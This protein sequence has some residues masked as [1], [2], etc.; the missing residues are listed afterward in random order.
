MDIGVEPDQTHGP[1]RRWALAAP[2]VLALLWVLP[3]LASDRP[4]L[5]RDYLVTGVPA[6][7]PAPVRR[8]DPAVLA[9]LGERVEVPPPPGGW[10]GAPQAVDVFNVFAGEVMV[11]HGEREVCGH[12]H[13]A[14]T[15]DSRFRA[16]VGMVVVPV[17]GDLEPIRVAWATP[18]KSRWIPTVRIGAPSPVQQIDTARL[19]VRTACVAVA[20]VLAFTALMGFLSARDGLF[21]G[22][23]LLCLLAVVWQAIVSGLSG[24]PEPWLPVGG[25]ASRW[26]VALSCMGLSALLYVMWLLVGAAGR[27]RACRQCLLRTVGGCWLLGIVLAAGLPMPALG[28]FAEAVDAIFAAGCVAVF[29]LGLYAAWRRRGD[30]LAGIAAILPFLVMVLLDLADSRLLIEYR[31]EA[32]QL[33]ITW[34]LTVSAYALNLRLGRLRRQRDEMQLLAD[35]DALTGLAN[36]RAGLVRLERHFRSAAVRGGML[37]VAFLDIDLFKRINDV[38]GHHAGD[39][40]LV[41]V[42]QTLAAA[43]RDAADVVRMGGEEFLVMLPGVSGDSAWQ[44]METVRT[45]VARVAAGLGIPGLTVT[46]SIGIASQHPQ[47][48]DASMLLRRADEAMY[49]A[50]R[51]GRNRVVAAETPVAGSGG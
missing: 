29:A 30:A 23:A 40:V 6:L 51:N 35:T 34:F 39:R 43:I 42:A 10:S 32:I 19:L 9:G 17:A 26:L 1:W 41:A 8:C 45:Q 48:H 50:K 5:G 47:D 4:E 49:R 13:D 38:H 21:L 16:G 3:G 18:L 27:G 44:R 28:A 33:S 15:R 46:A 2:F 24:Y 20:I 11:S 7:D 22:Y 37:S 36:R 31:V 25:E 12:M 14:R